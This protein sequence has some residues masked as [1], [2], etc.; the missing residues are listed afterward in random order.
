MRS[1]TET[2]LGLWNVHKIED[3]DSLYQSA[4]LI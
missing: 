2:V 3:Y 4:V 1:A